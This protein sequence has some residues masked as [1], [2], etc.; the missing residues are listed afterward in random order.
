MVRKPDGSYRVCGDYRR[1]NVATVPDRYPIPNINSLCSNLRGKNIFSKIDL[2]SAYHQV[3]MHPDDIQKTAIVTPFGLFEYNFMPFGLRNS[4]STFQRYMDDL[5]RNLPFVFVYLDDILVFSDNLEQHISHLDQIFK[6]LADNN[7]SIS[8]KKCVFCVEDVDFLGCNVSSAG[9]KPTDSKVKELQS[10]PYPNSSR[11]LRQFIGMVGFYRKFIPNFANLLYPLTERIRIESKNADFELSKD[12]KVAFDQVKSVLTKISPL[13]HPDQ[14]VSHYQIVVDASQYAIGAALHQVID[15]QAVP[16]G[17]FSKK[18]SMA[19]KKYSA[20]D[21]ELLAAYSSVLHFRHMI[22]GRNA[23]LITD[24]KPLVSALK[25]INS[26]KLDRQQRQLTVISEFV[27]DILHISGKDNIVADCLSRPAMSV[28]LDLCDLP[29]IAEE[30]ETDPEI[31]NF[32]ER[33]SKFTLANNK[34]VLCDASLSY[35]RPFVPVSLRKSVFQN[36]HNL[37]HPGVKSS[38]KLLKS[39]FFWPN[40]DKEIR[41]MCRECEDCQKAK[42]TRHTHTKKDHFELPSSR[43]QSIH[44]DI[45]G[46]LPPVKN[47]H[48]PYISSYSY[49][50]TCI[51]RA[52]R[53]VEAYPLEDITAMSVACTFLNW[54]SRFGVPLHVITDRGKQFESELFQELAKL[55]GFY[56][57]RTTAYHPQTNGMIE[58][59]HRTLKTAITARG[60]SW[61]L[62]LPIVLMSLRSIPNESGFSPF[63]AVTGSNMLMP[64][65]MIDNDSENNFDS[66]YV[67]KLVTEMQ[68]LDI[69]NMAMGRLHSKPK[70]FIPPELKTCEYVWLRVDRVRKALEAPYS[71]PYKVIDRSSKH[72]TI[73]INGKSNAVS[74]DRIKPARLPKSYPAPD[75]SSEVVESN[76]SPTVEPSSSKPFVTRSGRAVRFKGSDDIIYF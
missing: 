5:F 70:E 53:W 23:Y 64:Q 10:F 44:L 50:L 42:I 39:R 22:E 61:L 24:H 76:P 55:I 59:V 19:Q 63:T 72:F 11:S 74:M 4:S 48:N 34:S 69:D 56:R 29:K 68:K 3:P 12:E 31:S 1:L 66:E 36:F 46:P 26:A 27:V 47:I 2:L 35:P 45:I 52:T 54:I 28:T 40:I 17:F 58:R 62:S 6:I 7:L 20:F 8:V 38:V 13:P 73:D 25:S 21:R 67:K 15:N 37:S 71:G 41:E 14:S 51:D 57:L 32:T 16:I 65:I 9:A 60:N 75:T 18:L 33:L 43:F 49:V 30:Q